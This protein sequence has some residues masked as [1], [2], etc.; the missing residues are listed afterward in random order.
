VASGVFVN[1]PPAGAAIVLAFLLIGAGQGVRRGSEVVFDGAKF[2]GGMVSN[3]GAMSREP[4]LSAAPE[5]QIWTALAL[6]DHEPASAQIGVTARY[7]DVVLPM[8]SVSV[9]SGS[10]LALCGHSSARTAAALHGEAEL[11]LCSA[12]GAGRGAG[13]LPTG[14]TA[15]AARL[16]GYPVLPESSIRTPPSWTS[17]M[18]CGAGWLAQ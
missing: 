7:P 10:A 16:G 12:T 14:R 11:T 5:R 3:D 13:L 15:L 6:I 2:S 1:V 4:A 9:L 17:K 18:K 8:R